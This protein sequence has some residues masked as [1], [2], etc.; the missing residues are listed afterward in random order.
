MNKAERLRQ[1]WA[2]VRA[3]LRPAPVRK[4]NGGTITRVSHAELDGTFGPDRGKRLVW[5]ILPNGVLEIRPERTRRAETVSLVD[6]YRYAIHC[7]V[8]RARLE[9]ARERKS[10]LAEQRARRRLDS[11]ERRFR[12]RNVIRGEA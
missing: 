11:A 10:K 3:G 12:E 9:K 1:Y 4:G 8:N 6:V 2:D 5:T 7:R